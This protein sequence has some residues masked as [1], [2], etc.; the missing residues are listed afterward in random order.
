MAIGYLWLFVAWINAPRIPSRYRH[1]LI[2]MRANTDIH[3][4]SP[5]L[6]IL[7]VS[8]FAYLIGVFFEIVDDVS[9]KIAIFSAA[10]LSFIVLIIAA[11]LFIIFL[12]PVTLPVAGL[13]L[14]ILY[15]RVR[16]YHAK[17]GSAVQQLI[18]NATLLI[19][20]YAY[21]TWNLALRAW[22]A[23]N[24]VKNDL[25][26]EK[27]D[28]LLDSHPDL[29]KR[30]C[31]TLTFH[32]LR[33]ACLEAGLKFEDSRSSLRT[34][35][36]QTLNM[37][38]V[39]AR[40]SIDPD[41]ERL[42]REYLYNRLMASR[43]ARRSV[44]LRVMDTSDIRTLVNK[45]FDDIVA[46]LQANMPAAFEAYD[47]LRS[48][49][50]FRRGVAVPLGAALCSICAIYT[51]KPWLV[52]AA[53]IPLLFIYF[54]GMRKQEES[55]R[56]VVSWINAGIADIK[57]DVKNPNLL[58]WPTKVT[59]R[60]TILSRLPAYMRIRRSSQASA[61]EESDSALESVSDASPAEPAETP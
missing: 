58:H 22:S 34:A 3:R 23:A 11:F 24:P 56:T 6:A 37:A 8:F 28:E 4:L 39:A 13:I 35:D 33:A 21:S 9:L 30:F 20:S 45:A 17:L 40:S 50:E 43:A 25:I 55:A 16:R 14:A 19:R 59:T 38:K 47:R 51:S 15:F 49:G 41:S 53:G 36:N 32:A 31:D 61:V 29:I 10:T 48:E 18:I 26:A 60:T 42:L 27:A 1:S 44:V 12:W 46:R 52:T 7:I 54:S 5:I 57:L 2:V